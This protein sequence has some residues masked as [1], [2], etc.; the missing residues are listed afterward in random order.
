MRLQLEELGPNQGYLEKAGA[1]VDKFDPGFGSYAKR[2]VDIGNVYINANETIK[3]TLEEVVERFNS[4]VRIQQ[5]VAGRDRRDPIANNPD[6]APFVD[7]SRNVDEDPYTID[8][9]S[10]KEATK[11][12]LK[13][14]EQNTI[15]SHFLKKDLSFDIVAEEIQKLS[16]YTFE[17]EMINRD[18]VATQAMIFSEAFS[19][20]GS[21][22]QL[23]EDNVLR[24]ERIP[25]Y[26]FEDPNIKL[27]EEAKTE[28][29]G[30]LVDNDLLSENTFARMKAKTRYVAQSFDDQNLNNNF[31]EVLEYLTFT[32]GVNDDSFS[33]QS[34]PTNLT[35]AI[36]AFGS[37]MEVAFSEMSENPLDIFEGA[38]WHQ[39][40]VLLPIANIGLQVKALGAAIELYDSAVGNSYGN[41][42]GGGR[43]NLDEYWRLRSIKHQKD[44]PIVDYEAP[45]NSIFFNNQTM[46]NGKSA[47]TNLIEYLDKRSAEDNGESAMS[48]DD[49]QKYTNEFFVEMVISG[50]LDDKTY[51]RLK[52]KEAFDIDNLYGSALNVILTAQLDSIPSLRLSSPAALDLMLQEKVPDIY[53]GIRPAESVYA[54]RVARELG[55]EPLGFMEGYGAVNS[56]LG[57]NE[58]SVYH[59]ALNRGQ[60]AAI[61]AP[62]ERV[63]I[64]NMDLVTTALTTGTAVKRA[65]GSYGK[66]ISIGFVSGVAEMEKQLLPT[67]IPIRTIETRIIG[68]I[69]EGVYNPFGSH[70]AMK[71]DALMEN[72]VLASEASASDFFSLDTLS[73][74]GGAAAS[75]AVSYGVGTIL[76]GD[77]G[78]MTNLLINNPAGVQFL[79]D[80]FFR[81]VG[82]FPGDRLTE[83]RQSAYYY[84]QRGSLPYVVRRLETQK[85]IQNIENGRNVEVEYKAEAKNNNDFKSVDY[86][87]SILKNLG[88]DEAVLTVAMAD[89]ALRAT[90]E[91]GNAGLALLNARRYL[92]QGLD[93]EKMSAVQ[94]LEYEEQ[95]EYI[96]GLDERIRTNPDYKRVEQELNSFISEGEGSLTKSQIQL[97]LAS[98]R[99]RAISS[100]DVENFFR[101]IKYSPRVEF[102]PR[103]VLSQMFEGGSLKPD[104]LKNKLMKLPFDQQAYYRS[105]GIFKAAL[106][107]SD[108]IS[109]STI[110]GFLTS[111]VQSKEA[112]KASDGILLQEA[113]ETFAKIS[114]EMKEHDL[115]KM[116]ID[117]LDV[118]VY[119]KVSGRTLTVYE[120]HIDA[121]LLDPTEHGEMRYKAVEELFVDNVIENEVKSLAWKTDE[122]FS[123]VNDLVGIDTAKQEFQKNV[124]QFIESFK[125]TQKTFDSKATTET[126]KVTIGPQVVNSLRQHHGKQKTIT[127]ALDFISDTDDLPMHPMYSSYF[128]VSRD[129]LTSNVTERAQKIIQTRESIKDVQQYQPKQVISDASSVE[130]LDGKPNAPTTFRTFYFKYN[131]LFKDSYTDLKKKIEESDNPDAELKT[132][133]ENATK[134]IYRKIEE[135]RKNKSKSVQIELKSLLEDVE[136]V[137][138]TDVQIGKTIRDYLDP[139]QQVSLED[140]GLDIK[141]QKSLDLLKE[142]QKQIKDIRIEKEA[143]MHRGLSSSSRI[144]G[145]KDNSLLLRKA[146]LG[147]DNHAVMLLDQIVTGQPTSGRS[148]LSRIYFE[149]EVAERILDKE[150][151]TKRLDELKRD[152]Q[153]ERANTNLVPAED[154]MD[155]YGGPRQ[156]LREFLRDPTKN[157]SDYIGYQADDRA[158]GSVL[159]QE[160]EVAGIEYIEHEVKGPS[161][162][163]YKI[164]ELSDRVKNTLTRRGLPIVPADQSRRFVGIQLHMLDRKLDLFEEDTLPSVD[165][166]QLS[167]QITDGERLSRRHL[168][169][170]LQWLG[171]DKDTLDVQTIR[172]AINLHTYGMT[173]R[174]DTTI[175]G[176]RAMDLQKI[177]DE[178]YITDPTELQNVQD[179]IDELNRLSD[180]DYQFIERLEEAPFEEV[181]S[182]KVKIGDDNSL[183]ISE[184][185]T[186]K[187]LAE[188]HARS[189][190]YLAT[191][192]K[193]DTVIFQ[194]PSPQIRELIQKQVW[195]KTPTYNDALDQ[196][197]V[198]ITDEM[199]FSVPPRDTRLFLQ[200][201]NQKRSNENIFQNVRKRYAN[202]ATFDQLN[203]KQKRIMMTTNKMSGEYRR[204]ENHSIRPSKTGKSFVLQVGDFTRSFRTKE[205]AEK[206]LRKNYLV[207][208][209]S[210]LDVGVVPISNDPNLTIEALHGEIL[211]HIVIHTADGK[212]KRMVASK[213]SN[214]FASQSIT[215]DPTSPVLKDATLVMNVE[216]GQTALPVHLDLLSKSG[217]KELILV[218]PTRQMT[219]RLTG[220]FD[221]SLANSTKLKILKDRLDEKGARPVSIDVYGEV[222]NLI[223]DDIKDASPEQAVRL[224]LHAIQDYYN[225]KLQEIYKNIEVSSADISYIREGSYDY[226]K[227]TGNLEFDSTRDADFFRDAHKGLEK[228]R[229]TADKK[230]RKAV[231]E[232]SSLGAESDLIEILTQPDF[233]DDPF[234][235]R[236][237]RRRIY[238][239]RRVAQ[240]AV[241]SNIK[242][243]DTADI[244]KF[245][246]LD[247]LNQ[248]PEWMDQLNSILL[249]RFDTFTAGN[250][251]PSEMMAAYLI[252]VASQQAGNLSLKVLREKM[253]QKG[254]QA[255]LSVM[256]TQQIDPSNQRFTLDYIHRK[257]DSKGKVSHIVRAED[258]ASAWLTT[259]AGRLALKRFEEAVENNTLSDLNFRELFKP[260]IE[261]RAAWGTKS[262]FPYDN[263][264][265]QQVAKATEDLN[266]IGLEYK[267]KLKESDDDPDSG[268][269]DGTQS[270]MEAA[271]KEIDGVGQVKAPFLAQILG[272]GAGSTIDAKEVDALLGLFPG[273]KKEV[274]ENEAKKIN[275]NARKL[276][277]QLSLR[278]DI[279]PRKE[280][281]IKRIYTF[282]GKPT[283]KG[284]TMNELLRIAIEDRY[285][286]MSFELAKRGFKIRPEHYKALFHQWLWARMASYEG[287]RI[288]QLEMYAAILKG[289]NTM[290]NAEADFYM[291]QMTAGQI[292]YDLAMQQ[293]ASAIDFDPAYVLPQV[294]KLKAVNQGLLKAGVPVFAILENEFPNVE[295]HPV[296]VEVDP[297]LYD[298]NLGQKEIEQKIN[299][300]YRALAHSG[301]YKL[302]D[303]DEILGEYIGS[304]VRSEIKFSD[305][306]TIRAL[307]HENTHLLEDLLLPEEYAQVVDYFDHVEL[308]DGTKRLTLRGQEDLA[309]LYEHYRSH[310]IGNKNTDA[311]QVSN[312]IRRAFRYVTQE[313]FKNILKKNKDEPLSNLERMMFAEF[314][315]GKLIGDHAANLSEQ[316]IRQHTRDVAK[317]IEGLVYRDIQGAIETSARTGRPLQK[318]IRERLTVP[319]YPESRQLESRPA[320]AE[321]S[322]RFRD[323]VQP[324]DELINELRPSQYMDEVD[325]DGPYLQP[326]IARAKENIAR[327]SLEREGSRYAEEQVAQRIQQFFDEEQQTIPLVELDQAFYDLIEEGKNVDILHLSHRVK[328]YVTSR[329]VAVRTNKRPQ[330]MLTSR[331]IVNKEDAGLYNNLAIGRITKLFG[332]STMKEIAELFNDASNID[333][334]KVRT[335]RDFKE[336]RQVKALITDPDTI[337]R[338]QAFELETRASPG[339]QN[340]PSSLRNRIM[341]TDE[342]GNIELYLTD[343]AHIRD[344]IIDTGVATGSRRNKSLEDGSRSAL[345]SLAA[346]LRNIFRGKLSLEADM[347]KLEYL[348]DVIFEKTSPRVRQA[349]KGGDI[350]ISSRISELIE[351]FYREMRAIPNEVKN[352]LEVLRR[353]KTSDLEIS[354]P[355]SMT[356]RNPNFAKL[357][358]GMIE[359]GR[360]IRRFLIPP[361]DITY[362][363]M[364]KTLMTKIKNRKELMGQNFD[365]QTSRDLLYQRHQELLNLGV[366]DSKYFDIIYPHLDK[367]DEVLDDETATKVN[368]AIREMNKLYHQTMAVG[369]IL[370]IKN[371]KDIKFFERVSTLFHSTN[372]TNREKQALA[373]LQKYQRAEQIDP[374]NIKQLEADMSVIFAGV[375]NRYHSVLHRG[376]KILES[377]QGGKN[378]SLADTDSNM[379]MRAYTLFYQ[380]KITGGDIDVESIRSGKPFSVDEP[381]NLQKWNKGDVINIARQYGLSQRLSDDVFS[382]EEVK[383]KIQKYFGVKLTDDPDELVRIANRIRTNSTNV[384]DFRN[385]FELAEKYGETRI[386]HKDMKQDVGQII[387]EMLMRIIADEKL[388]VLA[389]K[390]AETHQFGDLR[391]ISRQK[392]IE[393][394]FNPIDETDEFLDLIKTY[395]TNYLSNGDMKLS[396]SFNGQ[397]SSTYKASTPLEAAAKE[398]TDQ[399]IASYRLQSSTKANVEIY[400]APD[401]TEYV[402]PTVLFDQIMNLQDEVSPTGI[403]KTR[404][405]TFGEL[406]DRS[407]N[408]R[409]I[410][411][412]ILL[413]ETIKEKIVVKLTEQNIDKDLA[414]QIADVYMQQKVHPEEFQ[415]TAE[416]LQEKNIFLDEQLQ[417]VD[418][419]PVDALSSFY[420]E[421]IEELLEEKPKF[422]FKKLPEEVELLLNAD[423]EI[424][425]ALDLMRQFEDVNKGD[426]QSI[427]V[428][429]KTFQVEGVLF[430]ND[431]FRIRS[432]ATNIA[433]YVIEAIRTYRNKPGLEKFLDVILARPINKFLKQSV[434]S[435]FIVPNIAYFINNAIGAVMQTYT[436]EG[437][438]GISNLGASIARNPMFFM[439]AYRLL[440]NNLRFRETSIGNPKTIGGGRFGVIFNSLMEADAHDRRTFVFATK[441]GRLYTP[442]TLIASAQQHGIGSSYITAELGRSLADDIRRS[443]AARYRVLMGANHFYRESANAVD[444]VFRLSMYMNHLYEGLS[445]TEAATLT[446][447]MYY[448]YADLTDFEKNI[449]REAFLF[450]SYAR[451]NQIQHAR[452]LANSPERVFAKL[453]MIRDSQDR[454]AED[455]S[456]PRLMAPYLQG[457]YMWMIEND[458]RLFL[459]GIESYY[460]YKDDVGN[461]VGYGP[462]MGVVD[463]TIF[464]APITAAY[465]ENYTLVDAFNE[466][467]KYSVSQ[468]ATSPRMFYEMFSGTQ[469]FNGQDLRKIKIDKE[470]ADLI[471]TVMKVNV[472]A[473]GHNPDG[474]INVEIEDKAYKNELYNQKMMLVPASKTD[475]FL[476]YSLLLLGSA[477]PGPSTMLGRGQRQNR[478]AIELALRIFGGAKLGEPFETTEGMTLYDELLRN[479]SRQ[480][481]ILKSKEEQK[482]FK[483][484]E[485]S[486]K[487]EENNP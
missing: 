264:V 210:Q 194:S 261:M 81:V 477:L 89:L 389:S 411:Q 39:Y 120:I 225:Q 116:T 300:Q 33:V 165:E 281:R 449:F 5:A 460:K 30:V 102:K 353:Q 305:Q 110:E 475:T 240:I 337:D 173:T 426:K 241:Y 471:N 171:L 445:E 324:N 311:A 451:K 397:F 465:Y 211:P 375:E 75:T 470:T 105:K 56:Y 104:E 231:K 174:K 402:L 121:N 133:L 26:L 394:G 325:V 277:N 315:P 256:L 484:Y 403:A 454:A 434:T 2:H 359:I 168:Q 242:Y 135:I 47:K 466:F 147:K 447:N 185:G 395:L 392:L 232:A 177:V 226:E 464:V 443:G 259:P 453:R 255:S 486:K 86:Y 59:E 438:S 38:Y 456:D 249:E 269:I 170:M 308:A 218:T 73:K 220:E 243:V 347:P 332:K 234:F 287:S 72:A 14:R 419:D 361:V 274:P 455:K 457:R 415:K 201:P 307:I 436:E 111:K 42:Y 43:S 119:Y 351:E 473:Y 134:N 270:A 348:L 412:S 137:A 461:K 450:Y 468:G 370:S 55:G 401:G 362:L 459:R 446:R 377:V 65:G 191:Q 31:L 200:D 107:G 44:F 54:D 251:K 278:Y 66:A 162:I 398:V 118:Y 213:T 123:Q 417:Q 230:L 23:S 161:N 25:Q 252:T 263:A 271:I 136:A 193:F 421:S 322:A 13:T 272:F 35:Y 113:L 16:D 323:T 180:S 21:L 430:G 52:E 413:A 350:E 291:A 29:I 128:G 80:N 422:R 172:D 474:L 131:A 407:Y 367:M 101:K 463:A 163:P 189:I 175:A 106:F 95:A 209:N 153:L 179:K 51:Q 212:I 441:D 381:P 62:F 354:F 352:I 313:A 247:D 239:A 275:F 184:S 379:L 335:Y 24:A 205:N 467:L 360:L 393:N 386:R 260:I 373:N 288:A 140:T 224:S 372:I 458:P 41:V 125:K 400:R 279:G 229:P 318:I 178:E 96:L 108:E 371:M 143:T 339:I 50:D 246:G 156:L 78:G 32:Q 442:E 266:S 28:T 164:I 127:Q 6:I 217:A 250:I 238:A 91:Q 126:Q 109:F 384:G 428:N 27:P 77:F 22:E 481:T 36:S 476:L 155:L 418:G 88:I 437:L 94:R 188:R 432:T 17:S 425:E 391:E 206:Y 176:Q 440:W 244:E 198:E 289:R 150:Q 117:G 314:E 435:G 363:P 309:D 423:A 64:A 222:A 214:N 1:I 208:P 410:S 122:V 142:E 76:G 478:L 7:Y 69:D 245:I 358:P 53:E 92:R 290:S 327:K 329:D 483:I 154:L 196:L 319:E 85:H 129:R 294:H 182:Y 199:K 237:E 148:N 190:L 429:P 98:L 390:I 227:G 334:T 487:I 273:W 235:K 433:T 10:V 336:S 298:F 262:N 146:N 365:I 409:R 48:L 203:S 219:Y 83:A 316:K 58:G 366:D 330:V 12:L 306:P 356:K 382:D 20:M 197:T 408:E 216:G 346:G 97:E 416:I 152:L 60:F 93:E 342:N 57:F 124:Y 420:K 338:L 369:D 380:G 100:G 228:T 138:V 49:L 82:L 115:Q 79:T 37:T 444:N 45:I 357:K 301:L 18:E 448:D 341:N 157:Q 284:L 68:Q 320:K 302:G 221:N 297:S 349:K 8:H 304:G 479:V 406:V 248:M 207:D 236:T 265:L 167:I 103:Q 70:T 376:G 160:F 169:S 34:Q 141:F 312:F 202:N 282:D 285:D 139:E 364:L 181:Y 267:R 99:L 292:G 280:N 11:E 132:I 46:L 144:F 283:D 40:P 452:A 254:T 3:E 223:S 344:A 276:L 328:A 4:E 130:T 204:M 405:I 61:I 388:N 195:G 268:A 303:E 485:A 343:M 151:R 378:V 233:I 310:Q 404:G 374:A 462:M 424:A 145:T 187:V 9:P 427:L 385:L 472:F 186:T 326:E 159:R 215:I 71:N 439:R 387:L 414:N 74:L 114:D 19:R 67:Y 63:P 355:D 399:I 90:L 317:I 295:A 158:L 84:Q 293:I 340:L 480:S 183:T 396:T 87:E 321:A 166:T 431:T 368:T 296:R 253:E 299:E 112:I 469:S 383:T 482:E 333:P 257:T 192:E 331:T 149:M 286:D 345:F 258:L 15:L